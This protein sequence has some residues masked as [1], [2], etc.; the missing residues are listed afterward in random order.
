MRAAL[1]LVAL[2]GVLVMTDHAEPGP[3]TPAH[4]APSQSRSAFAGQPHVG[5]FVATAVAQTPPRRESHVPGIFVVP[6]QVTLE[7]RQILP[8]VTQR[9]F[10]I[11]GARGEGREAGELGLQDWLPT[12]VGE[13]CVLALD[14][15]RAASAEEIV[16]L[17]GGARAQDVW[18]SVRRFFDTLGPD[19]RLEAAR[20]AVAIGQGPPP[21]LVFFRL[22]VEHDRAV[23]RDPEVMRALGAYLGNDRVP[24]LERRNVV[25]HYM[26]APDSAQTQPLRDLAGGMV[27]L[28]GR[29]GQD[30][31]VASADVVLQRLWGYVFEPGSGSAR[32]TTPDLGAAQREQVAQVV[33]SSGLSPEARDAMRAWLVG[34]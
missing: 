34:W 23:F 1:A 3:G 20:V 5:W 18:Q 22:L 19:L 16:F 31:Q 21:G 12:K 13:E 8:A 7:A 15:A 30:G 9:T 17:G 10:V 14:A 11:A 24:S 6:Y 33:A 29:L 2:T 26:G 27:Q 32:V 28:I 4:A 25:A